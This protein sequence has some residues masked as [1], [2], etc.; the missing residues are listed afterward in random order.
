MRRVG[1]D[2]RALAAPLRGGGY[3]THRRRDGVENPLAP[4]PSGPMVLAGGFLRRWRAAVPKESQA[5][6][7]RDGLLAAGS[8]GSLGA[9]RRVSRVTGQ[10]ANAAVLAG[11]ALKPIRV[12]DAVVRGS[13]PTWHCWQ[14]HRVR[15][16]YLGDT[17]RFGPCTRTTPGVVPKTITSSPSGATNKPNDAPSARTV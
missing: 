4:V 1:L 8:A 11:I 2:F 13:I 3:R 6:C 14:N 5:A 9:A 16:R 17:R 7:G 15:R 12:R 10:P